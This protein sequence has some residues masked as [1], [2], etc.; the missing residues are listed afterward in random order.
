MDNIITTSILSMAGLGLFFATVLAFANQKLKVKEDPKVGEIE[1]ALPGV[2]CGACGFT[3]CHLYAEALAKSENSPDQCKAGGEE[4]ACR[5]SEILGIEIGKKAKELAIVHCG[6]DQSKRKKKAKYL[7]VKTCKAVDAM[8]GGEVLCEYGCLGYSDCM[9]AC[10]FDAITMADGL[11]RID[12]E[13]CTA[14]GKCVAACPRGIISVEKIESKEFLFVACN[15]RAKGPETRKTCPVGCIACGICQRLTENIF[16][17]EKNLAEIKYEKMN[18]INN[19]EEVIKKCPT[20]CINK[21]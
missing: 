4:V 2:N 14:C 12:K 17:V 18:D 3:S 10:P 21:L 16:N 20:K 7:G 11:P 19:K 15:S 9:K 8:R 1:S 5:L 6:A 13:K